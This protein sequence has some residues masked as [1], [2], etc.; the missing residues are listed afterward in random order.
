MAWPGDRW[1]EFWGPQGIERIFQQAGGWPH[2][3]QLLAET[4]LDLVNRRSL[5]GVDPALFEEGLDK[6]I[7][8]GHNVLYQLLQQECQSDAEWDY[9][10]GFRRADTQSPPAQDSVCRALRGRLL[11]EKVGSVWRLRVPL[12]QRWLRQRG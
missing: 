9:L 4:L 8:R 1:P 3:V 10:S 5:P 11:V 2:L 7:V 6:A 12:M